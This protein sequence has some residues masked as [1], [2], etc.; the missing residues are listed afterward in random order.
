MTRSLRTSVRTSLAL[1]ASVALLSTLLIPSGA[2][3]S[4]HREAP[5]ISRDPT[6]DNTDLYAFRSPDGSN[7]VTLIANYIPLEEPAGGPNF[8]AFDDNV[9]YEIKVDN[10]GDAVPDVT[11]QF[12]FHTTR[13]NSDL[14]GPSFLFN[15]FVINSATDADLLVQQTYQVTRVTADR[16]VLLGSGHVPPTDVG[17]RSTPNYEANIGSGGVSNLSNGGK[18]FAGPRD[19][20]FFV[21]LGSIFDL[22]GLRPF[23]QAHLIPLSTQAGIDGVGGY[24]VHSIAVKIP[25]T[26]LTG[27]HTVPAFGSRKAVIGVWAT[28]SRQKVTVLNT[29]GTTNSNDGWVQVSRLGNPLINEVVIP[30]PKKDYWNFQQ[31]ANDSQFAKYYTAPALAKII[32][33]LYGTAII[34]LAG[35]AARETGRADLA[36][37]LLTGLKLPDGTPFTFTGTRQA[38]MLRLNVAIP[39]CT[40]DSATDVEGACSRLGVLSG[41]LAGFPNGRRLGDDVTDIELRAIADGYGSFVNS[42][43]HSLTPN[44]SPNNLIGDGVNN[45]DKPFLSV[46]PYVAPPWDGYDMGVTSFHQPHGAISTGLLN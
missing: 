15:D 27:T 44:N 3:A 9:L 2:L 42:L 6:A 5:L 13:H 30:L 31:P 22:G 1:L 25:I 38:D 21:D 12:R 20:P 14:F 41:D 11:Y 39:P 7:T 10:T 19:D 46:F 33:T 35:K 8:N 34:S 17:V 18:A 4:S 16:A 37:I 24:N 32:N 36:A 26:E 23:N 29:N 40:A 28:A 43:F 45:N